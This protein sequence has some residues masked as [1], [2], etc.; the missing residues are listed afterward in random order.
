MSIYF[1]SRWE[2]IEP[3]VT[4]K[5]VLDI[6]PAE[7][8]GTVNKEKSDRWLH[9]KIAD[10]ATYVLGLEKNQEQVKALRNLGFNIVAGDAETFAL[11]R[12]FD[13]I[14]A[15][16]LIEHLSNPGIFLEH[17]KKHLKPDG[18]LVMTTPNRFEAAA[19]FIAFLKN[20]IPSYEKQIA[21]HVCYFD[22]NCLADLLVRHGFQ[23]IKISY[24]E[25]VGGAKRKLV[26]HILNT[27]FR[28]FRPRFLQT[29]LVTAKVNSGQ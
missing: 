11:D 27:I 23:E 2:F 18:M 7:L 13:V 4:G 6:G 26:Y 15:G 14:F 12:T 22:E 29:L 8:V 17:V 21:R 3:Y 24:S 10:A 9:K 20:A 16:E 25:W 1:A 28:R 5:E 19:F